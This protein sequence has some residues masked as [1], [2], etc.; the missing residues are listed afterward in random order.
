MQRTL[1]AKALAASNV[2]PMATTVHTLRAMYV[3]Y[4]HHLYR[5]DCTFNR[6]A[7]K[8]LGHE[9][10]TVSLS[11]NSVVLHDIACAESLGPL[12]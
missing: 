5:C 2:F 12:P 6:M 10:L 11:Y 7:M 1:A 9:K 3:A 4:I 8:V